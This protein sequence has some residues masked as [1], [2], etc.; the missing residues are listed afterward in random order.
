MLVRICQI[1]N[2]SKDSSDFLLEVSQ[3]S[4]G[5]YIVLIQ[6]SLHCLL[7]SFLNDQICQEVSRGDREHELVP[8][9]APEAKPE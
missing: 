8:V 1:L 6:S 7:S 5:E 3:L 4:C 2:L 9:T